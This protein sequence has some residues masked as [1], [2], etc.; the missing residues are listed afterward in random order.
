MGTENHGEI[1]RRFNTRGA[2]VH[3]ARTVG[4]DIV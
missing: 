2:D 4:A 1:Q 3:V